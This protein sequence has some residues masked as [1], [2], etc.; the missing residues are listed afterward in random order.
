MPAGQALSPLSLLSFASLASL[1]SRLV[2]P[3]LGASCFASEVAALGASLAVPLSTWLSD[4]GAVSRLGA[5][6]AVC[7]AS[8][9]KAS[10]AGSAGSRSIDGAGFDAAQPT[11]NTIKNRGDRIAPQGSA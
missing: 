4:V 6:S 9:G 11:R 3:S 7:V 5:V 1:P 2:L 10:V 8:A